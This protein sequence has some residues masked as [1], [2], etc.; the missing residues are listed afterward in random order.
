MPRHPSRRTLLGAHIRTM[1]GMVIR[2]PELYS[3]DELIEMR[4]FTQ[5]PS[6]QWV[7]ARRIGSNMRTFQWRWNIAWLVLTG[8]CDAI[9]WKGQRK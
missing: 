2:Q 1:V 7:A 3:V 9:A 4:V 6:G 5:L 8:Q